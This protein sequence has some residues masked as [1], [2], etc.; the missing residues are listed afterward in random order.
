[1]PDQPRPKTENTEGGGASNLAWFLTG[2]VL[3]ATVAILYTP[4]SGKDTREFIS[5][6]T[7]QGKDALS[8]TGTDIVD[9]GRDMFD[10]GRKL[11]E[12]AAELF[13]R[14]RKLVRG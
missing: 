12:D 14:G 11:L 2:V 13:D 3:G 9:A 1:M 5:E 6:K 7:Q 10:R 4:K 8:Q